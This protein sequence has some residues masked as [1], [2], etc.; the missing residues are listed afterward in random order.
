MNDKEHKELGQDKKLTLIMF[1]MTQQRITSIDKERKR[2][3]HLN[4]LTHLF[5]A[6]M[7]LPLL[8]LPLMT[9]SQYNTLLCPKLDLITCF[10]AFHFISLTRLRNMTLFLNAM[11][12]GKPESSL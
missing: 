4:S 8:L 3:N 6:P 1:I 11:W 7:E 2:N 5:L 9:N 12:C 10:K